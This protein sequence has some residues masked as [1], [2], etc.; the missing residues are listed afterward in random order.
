MIE[1]R[2]GFVVGK[3][4]PFHK[5]H[6]FLIEAALSQ[7]EKVVVL[8]Y[9]SEFPEFDSETRANWIK[10]AFR[11]QVAAGELDVTVL[12]S[13]YDYIDPPDDDAAP[14]V[15]RDFCA[16]WL[17]YEKGI[18]VD[19]VFSS[20]EYGP[21]L[22]AYLE[23]F[24]AA[25]VG[26]GVKV[27]PVTVDIDRNTFRISGTGVR[28]ALADKNMQL[29]S[30]MVPPN[31]AAS[32]I[33]K[34]AFL[35]GESSGKTT[36]AR[37]MAAITRSRWVPEYGRELFAQRTRE[38]RTLSMADYVK[39]AEVQIRDEELYAFASTPGKYLWCD[40]TPLTTFWYAT[41]WLK[42]V[43][44]EL[45]RKVAETKYS[46]KHVFVCAPDFPFVQDGTRV[47]D[48][49]RLKGTQ[50]Y[51]EML[52]NHQIPFTVLSGTLE[53]RIAKVLEVTGLKSV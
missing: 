2:I 6:Q 1:Y 51:T 20:E 21:H 15:H 29:V 9:T 38:G 23:R 13:G 31:V 28:E 43:P 4:C 40:T 24:F 53:D 12:G 36:I 34:V 37:T 46:Y 11:S 41:Q 26:D 45:S 5:G 8:S 42:M 50:F 25:N 33:P 19:A 18:T 44:I 27:T 3:F 48:E 47:N 16:R 32:F 39:I 17:V 49:F 30:E 52:T 10:T 35:G 14:E 7:C 22:A